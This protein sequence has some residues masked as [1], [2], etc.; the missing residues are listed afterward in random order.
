[1]SSKSC[2]QSATKLS[3][4]HEIEVQFAK[5]TTRI[6]IALEKNNIHVAILIEQLCAISAV[7]SKKVP[8]FNEDV[9]EKIHSIDELWR[10]LRN[11]WNIFDYDILILVVDLTEC[12]E[13]KEILDNFLERIDPSALE[14]VDLVLR[15]TVHLEEGLIKPVLRMKVNIEKITHEIKKKAKEIVSKSFNIENYSLCF[16]GVKEGCVEIYYYISKALVSYLMEFKITGGIMTEFATHNIISLQVNDK[17]LNVQS[18][19]V[20]GN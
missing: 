13:A 6:K 19:M 14:D 11:F 5:M 12:A 4:F 15:C 3:N 9:F 8:I 16:R 1:M 7:R 17:M 18:N 10:K 20:S 2:E